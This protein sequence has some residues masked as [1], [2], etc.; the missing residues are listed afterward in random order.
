MVA[1]LL[2]A[3]TL[4][5]PVS[6]TPE[7]GMEVPP[8]NDPI[9]SESFID[10]FTGSLG[11]VSCSHHYEK[12]AADSGSLPGTTKD[13]T[14]CPCLI[15]VGLAL[16]AATIS[17]YGIY[18]SLQDDPDYT[19]KQKLECQADEWSLKGKGSGGYLRTVT[20][21]DDEG[22]G[23]AACKY[24]G[25]DVQNVLEDHCWARFEDD[26]GDLKY[27]KLWYDD[28]VYDT[29]DVCFQPDMY[30]RNAPA[31][32]PTGVVSPTVERTFDHFNPD[33]LCKNE[34]DTDPKSAEISLFSDL[35]EITDDLEL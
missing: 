10:S 35:E 2:L 27:E 26:S 29:A 13:Q 23:R 11:D 21:H 14:A 24:E 32:D 25:I 8:P 6:A 20:I 33:G 15:I 31:V 19:Y 34:I 28:L 12:V 1:V 4:A 3:S 30:I 18:K 5:S 9:E 22:V 17:A 7:T 16:L